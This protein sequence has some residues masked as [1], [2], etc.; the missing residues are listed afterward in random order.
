MPRRKPQPITKEQF[1]LDS[2]KRDELMARARSLLRDAEDLNIR[3]NV[4]FNFPQFEVR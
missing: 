2:L 3:V 4:R 1:D